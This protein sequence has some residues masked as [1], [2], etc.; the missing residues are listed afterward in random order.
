M[1]QRGL[2]S[3]NC[4]KPLIRRNGIKR[5]FPQWW[6]WTLAQN[7]IYLQRPTRL[8]GLMRA[9]TWTEFGP[10]EDLV[11]GQFSNSAF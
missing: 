8:K 10:A 11:T 3:T 9:M 2:A 7:G 4:T 1:A 5:V 6:A